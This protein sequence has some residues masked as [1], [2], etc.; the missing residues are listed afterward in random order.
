MK[1]KRVML[2]ERIEVD[3]KGLFGYWNGTTI[4]LRGKRDLQSPTM[5]WTWFHCTPDQVDD[6]IDIL[7]QLKELAEAVDAVDEATKAEEPWH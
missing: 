7:R 3:H 2:P 1:I 5:S 6:A 4:T